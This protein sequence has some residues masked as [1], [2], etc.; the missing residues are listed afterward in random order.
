MGE[1]VIIHRNITIEHI[2]TLINQ[3]SMNYLLRREGM[4]FINQIKTRNHDIY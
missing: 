4:L 1:R 3:T 2:Q